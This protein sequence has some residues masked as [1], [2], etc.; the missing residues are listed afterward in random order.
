ME[1]SSSDVVRDAERRLE[2]DCQ[3]GPGVRLEEPLRREIM[4]T[5]DNSSCDGNF[6]RGRVLDPHDVIAAGE[7][8]NR[9]ALLGEVIPLDHR[10]RA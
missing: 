3:D 1:V 4:R 8:P 9:I 7:R 5:F 2:P 6:T 10:R